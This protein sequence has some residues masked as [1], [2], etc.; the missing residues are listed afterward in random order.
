MNRV[1]VRLPKDD[2]PVLVENLVLAFTGAV[3]D[4]TYF[5]SMHISTTE[6]QMQGDLLGVLDLLRAKIGQMEMSLREA[7]G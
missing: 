5:V 7:V 2:E 6:L 3:D 4:G 1:Y